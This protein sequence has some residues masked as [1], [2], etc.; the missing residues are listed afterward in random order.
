MPH[1]SCRLSSSKTTDNNNPIDDNSNNKKGSNDY[2]YLLLAA[3]ST[4]GMI[5]S[6]LII[7]LSYV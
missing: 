4:C 3:F 1:D 5:A 7:F 6:L 2:D